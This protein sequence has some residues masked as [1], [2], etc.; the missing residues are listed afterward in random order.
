MSYI[1][2]DIW[3]EIIIYLDF[4]YYA[5]FSQLNKLF[6]QLLKTDIFIKKWMLNHYNG[7]FRQ[8]IFNL[9]GFKKRYKSL[10]TENNKFYID[11]NMFMHIIGRSDKFDYNYKICLTLDTQF[12]YN[13]D[14]LIK[15]GIPCESWF[16]LV[17]INHSYTLS[18]TCLS[19]LSK[20]L[21]IT[22]NRGNFNLLKIQHIQ[23]SKNGSV[24]LTSYAE[25]H[26]YME[27]VN[28]IESEYNNHFVFS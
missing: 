24:M 23:K 27:S 25:R 1:S 18:T 9:A 13:L 16:L 19:R 26:Q 7:W 17:A 12:K 2:Q 6:N 5:V 11:I 20:Y 28:H 21:K 8:S 14:Y 22:S 3:Q 4:N 10:Y 15:Y